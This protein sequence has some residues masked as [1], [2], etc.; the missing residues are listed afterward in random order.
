MVLYKNT[1]NNNHNNSELL[2]AISYKITDIP[3]TLNR[4]GKNHDDRTGN[5]HDSVENP[6]LF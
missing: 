2:H 6:A 5:D 1:L 3:M 4:T